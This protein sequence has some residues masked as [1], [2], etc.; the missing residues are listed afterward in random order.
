MVMSDKIEK[1]YIKRTNDKTIVNE[2]SQY[3]I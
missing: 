2:R 1:K 3:I